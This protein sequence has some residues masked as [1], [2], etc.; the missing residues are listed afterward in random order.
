M[1]GPKTPKPT[2]A[3]ERDP[4]EVATNRDAD[5]C[6]RCRRNCGPTARDHRKNR[7]QGGW[8]VPSNLQVLGL[9]CHT[10][11]TENPEDAISDGWAVPGWPTADWREWPARR[12]VPMVYGLRLGWVIYDDTGSW[13]EI[14][15]AEAHERMG[16]E[17]A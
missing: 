11:K 2:P 3:E 4:Y 16:R 8:T 9:G 5:M 17:A 14:T 15:E 1:I 13:T 6:Q 10:W 12:W 7:S